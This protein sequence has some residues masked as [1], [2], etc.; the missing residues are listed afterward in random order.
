VDRVVTEVIETAVPTSV[1]LTRHGPRALRRRFN[2]AML[3][4]GL[5]TVVL[6]V[7]WWF[8]NWPIGFPI[9][10]VVIFLL[11]LPVAA[12]RYRNLGHALGDGYL[13]TRQGSLI[14]RRY[15]LATAGIIGWNEQMSFFQRRAGL[16]TL[17]ATTAAGR[18]HYDVLDLAQ[19][20][21]IALADA[22]TPGLLTP[23]LT[24][25]GRPETAAD[26]SPAPPVRLRPGSTTTD[27]AT[28]DL[29]DATDESS[30]LPAAEPSPRA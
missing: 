28:D 17:V 22:A 7:L 6:G 9:G 21:A 25:S 15:M 10:G 1:T 16:V 19:P 13:V 23:F 18:Q 4:T 12:D 27:N 14:R 3:V 26:R 30:V 2:R 29:T 8:A 20:D 11:A 24:T 5:L